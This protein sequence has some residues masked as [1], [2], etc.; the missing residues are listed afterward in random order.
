[1]QSGLNNSETSRPKFKPTTMKR[2]NHPQKIN[3]ETIVHT[4]FCVPYIWK[5]LA[6]GKNDSV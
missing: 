4:T 6:Y 2:E 1:M 5:I 3:T